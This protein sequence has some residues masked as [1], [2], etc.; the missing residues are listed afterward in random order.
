MEPKSS[1]SIL[2]LQLQLGSFGSNLNSS[3]GSH[4]EFP[5]N[6]SK[7]SCKWRFLSFPNDFPALFSSRGIGGKFSENLEC[8]CSRILRVLWKFSSVSLCNSS[9]NVNSSFNSSTNLARV[10]CG[11]TR[12][13]RVPPKLLLSTIKGGQ[14]EYS[15]PKEFSSMGKSNL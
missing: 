14:L 6:C 13:E 3:L 10:S 4:V 15:P 8:F 11:Y 9:H 1:S 7:D 2:F 5:G 12:V